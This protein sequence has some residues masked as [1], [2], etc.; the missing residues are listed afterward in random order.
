M[1]LPHIDRMYGFITLPVDHVSVCYDK[2]RFIVFKKQHLSFDKWHSWTWKVIFIS[3]YKVVCHGKWW[4]P[5]SD[6]LSESSLEILSQDQSDW[7][8]EKVGSPVLHS[9][10]CLGNFC[11]S[12]LIPSTNNTCLSSSFERYCCRTRELIDDSANSS[13]QW[14]SFLQLITSSNELW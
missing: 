4:F 1:R 9:L 11:P 7:L 3:A 10:T 8:V 2:D 5:S 13:Q 6:R 12:D 14:L